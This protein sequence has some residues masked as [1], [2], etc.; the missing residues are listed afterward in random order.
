VA[1]LGFLLLSG[2]VTVYFRITGEGRDL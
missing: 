1:T 2:V